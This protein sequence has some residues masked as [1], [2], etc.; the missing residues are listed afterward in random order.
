M[1]LQLAK[2]VKDYPPE[3]ALLIKDLMAKLE[4]TFRVYGFA[5]L[6]TPH[7]ERLDV[8]AAKYAGGAEILKETFRLKDQGGRELALRYDLTVPFSRFIGMN[9]TL[10]MPFKRYQ[11]GTVFR[12]GP[13]KKGRMR[14]FWQCDVDVVG[15]SS[16][17]ADAEMVLIA[18]DIFQQLGIPATVEVNNRKILDGILDA[19]K[20]PDDKKETVLV[21]IDKFK[22]IT[23]DEI[24]KEFTTKGISKEQQDKLL[25][26]LKPEG[27]NGQKL[28]TIKK[29]V[30]S[31]HGKQGIAEMEELM[32]YVGKQKGVAFSPSLARGLAYYTGTIFEAFTEGF[33]SSL[34]GGGRYDTMIGSF[35]EHKREYPAVGISFGVVPIL[36]VLAPAFKS[37]T[38]T[39]VYVIP[40][41]VRAEALGVVQE[42]RTAKIP[43]DVDLIG[44]NPSK[45]LEYANV[46][47][48]PFVLFIGED[49][50]KKNLFKLKDMKTGKEEL[51][52]KEALV[53]KLSNL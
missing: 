15:T 13:L 52:K 50:L 6:E 8:L 3:E 42:L 45:N 43:T 25:M 49:E 7:L 40:I 5:P 39:Q 51:L 12:D 21:T 47:G 41:G 35:L 16:M 26:L 9:P 19:V 28:S 48:I 27:N 33:S 17:M 44:K 32:N 24:C 30:T 10:K 37:K 22:K 11:I 31:E 23:S 14:E 38:P 20:I 18:I 29:A 36:A 1:E 34:A 46:Q 4:A 53:K 2:G